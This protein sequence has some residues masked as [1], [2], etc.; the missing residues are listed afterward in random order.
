M[1]QVQK[2]HTRPDPQVIERDENG[3]IKDPPYEGDTNTFAGKFF[4]NLHEANHNGANEQRKMGYKVY[5]SD[6]GKPPE[7]MS[8][9]EQCK[10]SK[11]IFD[12]VCKIL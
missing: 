10:A 9:Y 11:G 5:V 7:G 8:H 2:W 12:W 1:N 6:P 3:Y 4:K